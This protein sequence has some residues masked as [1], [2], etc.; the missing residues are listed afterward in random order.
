MVKLRL[1]R[2][3]RHK[4]PTYRIVA[5]DSKTKAN[6]KYIELLGKYDPLNETT[7]LNKEPIL[8]WLTTGA[9][10]TD[11]VRS[12]LR[13]EKIMEEF[14][15]LKKGTEVQAKTKK[16]KKTLTVKKDPVK[17]ETKDDLLSKLDSVKSNLSSKYTEEE[18]KKRETETLKV[19]KEE[20]IAVSSSKDEKVNII[21]SLGIADVQK[22][23]EEDKIFLFM[24]KL[25]VRDVQRVLIYAIKPVGLVIGEFDL[26][27]T[28]ALSRNKAW[29]EYGPRSIFSKTQ[30]DKYF[31]NAAIDGVKMM[32]IDGFIKYSKP[33]QISEF[34]MSRG[35]SGFAYLK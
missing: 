25:P 26:K 17:K 21:I 19:A 1:L 33:K 32:E 27:S 29:N 3:G 15:N 10:P 5:V 23:L 12:I 34:S 20:E 22:I 16:E 7:S 35:P 4:E 2:K 28:Q 14:V 13:K 8:K 31:E 9:Q 11:T 6:G 18:I 30:F 24:K